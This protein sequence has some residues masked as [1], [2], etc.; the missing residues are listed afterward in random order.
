MRGLHVTGNAAERTT[1]LTG[2]HPRT[3]NS[4]RSL[5]ARCES[6]RLSVVSVVS[7]LRRD[8]RAA[9]SLSLPSTRA[10]LRQP[11]H[12]LDALGNPVAE[13]GRYRERRWLL[14]SRLRGNDNAEEGWHPLVDRS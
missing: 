2:G 14:D 7:D 6:F 5:L 9:S 13:V 8:V 10:W 3:G 4:V 11:E 1:I 12:R